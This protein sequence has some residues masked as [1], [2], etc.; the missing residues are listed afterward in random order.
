MSP[1][2]VMAYI[3]LTVAVVI[4]Y[5][6]FRLLEGIYDLLLRSLPLEA[7]ALLPPEDETAAASEKPRAAGFRQSAK[8]AEPGGLPKA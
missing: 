1:L 2:D 8:D 6:T 4:L 7:V 5:R 3:G